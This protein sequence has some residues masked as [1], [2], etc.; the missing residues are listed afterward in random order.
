MYGRLPGNV[1]VDS[2]AKRLVPTT[3]SDRIVAFGS[4]ER[5]S[6]A[7]R[8]L[9]SSYRAV[10]PLPEDAVDLHD[11]EDIDERDEDVD[12]VSYREEILSGIKEDAEVATLLQS[13]TRSIS[14]DGGN[15]EEEEEEEEEIPLQLEERPPFPEDGSHCPQERLL[16]RG[17]RGRKVKLKDFKTS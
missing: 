13:M 6:S 9:S 3:E 16:F 10:D 8:S 7:S 15:E 11:Q 12:S 5:R 4:P 17:L 14:F 1:V 2:P